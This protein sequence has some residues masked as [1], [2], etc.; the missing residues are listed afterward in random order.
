MP[1]QAEEQV[2]LAALVVVERADH[3]LARPREVRL[4][5]R[6]RQ[7]AR[8]HQLHEEAAL[9]VE[10]AQRDARDYLLAPVSSIRRPTSARSPQCLPPSCHQ[11]ST[12]STSSSPLLRVDAVDVG[13]LELAAVRRREAVDDVEHVRRVAVEADDRVVRRR[14]VVAR[15]DDAGLLDDVGDRA[16]VAVDDDAE[17]LRVGDVLREHQRAVAPRSR[18]RRRARARRC[19]RRGRRRASRRAA[20]SRAMPTT[21]AI[22]PASTC[23]LYERSR[24]NSTSSPHARA[25][26]GRCRAGR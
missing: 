1:S 12:R 21:C 24:S 10:P 5:D 19:C 14:R 25:R 2:V 6:L 16:V 23:T 26:R 20:K 7:L 3:A 17:V 8:A 13:D 11:P 15:V 9:V 18:S 22:P 4:P